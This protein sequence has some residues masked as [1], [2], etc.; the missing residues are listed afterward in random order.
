MRIIFGLSL[1]NFFFCVSKLKGNP[2]WLPPQDKFS[3]YSTLWGKYLK[4]I[5][6]RNCKTI[7]WQAK[8]K[9]SLDC[10]YQVS[11]FFLCVDHKSKV[12]AG[13]EQTLKKT[14]MY[15]IAIPVILL[16]IYIYIYI[17]RDVPKVFG[18]W[19]FYIFHVKPHFL[20][21][22]FQSQYLFDFY[23]IF[24]NRSENVRSFLR[25]FQNIFWEHRF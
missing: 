1:T 23:E 4:E 18:H 9:C 19:F 24:T 5:H 13:I 8:L 10:L 3:I 22:L 15:R 11:V 14:I 17:Y 7:W 21:T 25:L 12:V 20:K 16:Y 2:R 6:I